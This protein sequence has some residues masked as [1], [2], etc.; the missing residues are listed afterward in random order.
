MLCLMSLSNELNHT[1]HADHH[2]CIYYRAFTLSFESDSPSRPCVT[3]LADVPSKQR[4]G[5]FTISC[6]HTKNAAMT[7]IFKKKIIIQRWLTFG[8]FHW[9]FLGRLLSLEIPM[10]AS[11]VGNDGSRQGTPRSVW[12]LFN[13]SYFWSLNTS[14]MMGQT[15]QTHREVDAFLEL[16]AHY[17]CVC[18]FDD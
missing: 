17:K 18:N 7:Q 14:I 9:I 15:E 13:L 2:V 8:L 1:D 11:E 5:S 12:C 3:S 16:L 4:R 10:E 6:V